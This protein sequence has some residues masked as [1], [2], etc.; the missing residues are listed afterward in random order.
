M[1]LALASFVGMLVYGFITIRQYEENEERHSF[2][3]FASIFIWLFVPERNLGANE[4]N[5]KVRFQ[6]LF[7]VFI[8]GYLGSVMF[9]ICSE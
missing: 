6:V 9:G 4:R 7:A 1:L 8:A 2:L 3:A 5:A